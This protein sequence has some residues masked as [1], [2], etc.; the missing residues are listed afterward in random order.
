MWMCPNGEW[1]RFSVEGE[2][3]VL[4]SWAVRRTVHTLVR[5][6]GILRSVNIMVKET[7]ITLHLIVLY[8]GINV[9]ETPM[10]MFLETGDGPGFMVLEAHFNNFRDE[11][12]EKVEDG[13]I[14]VGI[15]LLYHCI[16]DKR[17][18][19]GLTVEEFAEWSAEEV[20]TTRDEWRG[21]SPGHTWARYSAREAGL[22]RGVEERG[23]VDA[24]KLLEDMQYV[25]QESD[26]WEKELPTGEAEPVKP[27]AGKA[28]VLEKRIGTGSPELAAIRRNDV[29]DEKVNTKK[30]GRKNGGG[31]KK[32]KGQKARVA[33]WKGEKYPEDPEEE[34]VELTEDQEK[35][36]IRLLVKGTC[37]GASEAYVKYNQDVALGK[38]NK[39]DGIPQFEED[40]TD[41][42]GT[43]PGGWVLSREDKEDIKKLGKKKSECR[44]KPNWAKGPKEDEKEPEM[45]V[46]IKRVKAYTD[47]VNV[48]V[49][50]SDNVSRASRSTIASP[51][52]ELS[53]M[54]SSEKEK[55]DMPGL[56]TPGS[57]TSSSASKTPA[58]K[59][60]RLSINSE[61]F[62][63]S[64]LRE[65]FLSQENP[66][67]ITIDS[68]TSSCGSTQMTPRKLSLS[69]MI[70]SG[71]FEFPENGVLNTR[72]I[73]VEIEGDQGQEEEEDV[74]EEEKE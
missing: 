55:K 32:G 43:G 14:G 37:P 40:G 18:A 1:W 22:V 46:V 30:R 8:N 64:A 36:I 62:D 7:Q 19:P 6:F 27:R 52:G 60:V 51:R 28:V 35:W 21:Q 69:D 15:R 63:M 59:R 50:G 67:I 13:E 42:Y 12:K 71:S 34:K 24:E 72:V 17:L 57:A 5:E 26:S 11:A 74:F 10:P 45:K 20:I 53:W 56:E 66:M 70:R 9:Q 16:V 58:A 73:E 44:T 25:Q 68:S 29:D 2:E 41:A 65:P 33:W 39:D 47:D 23:S 38:V 54:G 4:E 61:V 31:G 48:S 49:G 3:I